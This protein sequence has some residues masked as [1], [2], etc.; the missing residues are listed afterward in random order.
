MCDETVKLPARATQHMEALTQYFLQ[1]N[2]KLWIL[3]LHSQAKAAMLFHYLTMTP[4]SKRMQSSGYTHG[5]GGLHAQQWCCLPHAAMK[6]GG[7][8]TSS[9]SADR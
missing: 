5:G 2:T 6:L 8:T 9:R 4:M 1:A 7:C 3:A